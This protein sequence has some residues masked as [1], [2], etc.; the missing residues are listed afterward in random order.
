MT[1]NMSTTPLHDSVSEWLRTQRGTPA[2]FAE[3]D[4]IL[5][6]YRHEDVATA[7]ILS[8]VSEDDVPLHVAADITQLVWEQAHLEA[9]VTYALVADDGGW[10]PDGEFATPEEARAVLEPWMRGRVIRRVIVE[11]PVADEAAHVGVASTSGA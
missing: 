11:S 3:L 6:D 4:R 7:H 2:D 9:Q 1:K 8:R 10:V 5:A